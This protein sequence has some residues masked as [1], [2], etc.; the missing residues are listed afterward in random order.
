MIIIN[1][2]KRSII[3]FLVLLT[4]FSIP[5]YVLNAITLNYPKILP[6]NLGLG[7]FAI[8]CPITIAVILIYR[9]DSRNGVKNLLFEIIKVSKIKNKMW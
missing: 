7:S 3:N 4:I 2:P 6:L 8:V 9:E 1:S 5:F